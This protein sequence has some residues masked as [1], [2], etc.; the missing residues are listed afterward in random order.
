MASLEPAHADQVL[1]QLREHNRPAYRAA[2]GL[3]ASRRK[4]RVVF[5]DKKPM[6]ERHA[7]MT[8]EMTKK[9]NGDLAA[10]I[11]Q[12]WLFACQ[13]PML[14]EF[15]DAIGVAHDGEGMIESL[16][17]QPEEGVLRAGIEGLLAK[18]PAWAVSI[19]L[20]LFCEMDIA[21][22]P[23]LAEILSQHPSLVKPNPAP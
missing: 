1:A 12:G 7:W 3:L 10:E 4:L 18:H 17:E 16:P 20:H 15:L 2:A 11:L 23:L 13:K 21:D 5:L 8:T 22:W 14:C 9:S 6:P 19:Y